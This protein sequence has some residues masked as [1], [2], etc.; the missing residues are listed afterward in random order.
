MWRIR[1]TGC[2]QPSDSYT[3]T[4][5]SVQGRVTSTTG[6]YVVIMKPAGGTHWIT[7]DPERTEEGNGYVRHWHHEYTADWKVFEGE[8]YPS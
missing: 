1:R 4:D 3:G 8:P 7:E 6:T 2:D 5:N